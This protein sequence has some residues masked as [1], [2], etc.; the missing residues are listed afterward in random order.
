[1]ALTVLVVEDHDIVRNYLCARIAAQPG[2]RVVGQAADGF[3]AMRQ[4]EALQPDLILLDV[5]LPEV[6]GLTAAVR[7]RTLAPLAKILFVS[8]TFSVDLIETALNLGAVGYVHKLRAETELGHAVQ[9]IFDGKYFVSG[10]RI[11]GFGDARLGRDEVRHEV[12]L[13]S[14]ATTCAAGFAEFIAAAL[15]DGRAA[16]LIAGKSCRCEVLELLRAKNVP[17]EAAVERRLFL[18]VDTGDAASVHVLDEI[19]APSRF[20]EAA[21]DLF[22]QPIAASRDDRRSRAVLCRECSRNA[23]DDGVLNTPVRLEQRW[24][25]IARVFGVDMLCGYARAGLEPHPGL[26]RAIHDEHTAVHSR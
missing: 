22:E 11:N 15:E 24:R 9:A 10:V 19:G 5:G 4:A 3:E 8:Q 18:S 23:D 6:N 16:I 7:I 13:C 20:L 2:F 26:L 1:M 17:L 21:A 25:L 14:A 12:Q